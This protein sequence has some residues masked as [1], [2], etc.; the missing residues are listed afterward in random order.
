MCKCDLLQLRETTKL[1]LEKENDPA[2]IL[3]LTCIL[4]YYTSTNFMLNFPGRLVPT[5]LESIKKNIVEDS[6]S[7][8][9]K[10]QSNSIN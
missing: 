8:L 5:V 9:I 1:N 3:Q 6:Y 7:K 4:L 10:L 2:T